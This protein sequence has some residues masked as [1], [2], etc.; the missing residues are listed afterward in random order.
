[1][2]N[3]RPLLAN[4]TCSKAQIPVTARPVLLASAKPVPDRLQQCLQHM[5]VH[6]MFTGS[7]FLIL[8]RYVMHRECPINQGS[9]RQYIS[10][11][12]SSTEVWEE[13][14]ISR[15]ATSSAD[16]LP[17]HFLTWLRASSI[18]V[19]TF[20]PTLAILGFQAVFLT[21]LPSFSVLTHPIDDNSSDSRPFIFRFERVC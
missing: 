14:T 11:E 16:R 6:G 5:E 4:S 15:T 17:H 3:I 13:A 10:P 9:V 7:E 8:I 12:Q 2:T 19:V 20:F 1:M 21:V 18:S